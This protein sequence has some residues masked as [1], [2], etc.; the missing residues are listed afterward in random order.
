MKERWAGNWILPKEVKQPHRTKS[1]GIGGPGGPLR[2]NDYKVIDRLE[3]GLRSNPVP[4]GMPG[5]AIE[6]TS[7]KGILERLWRNNNIRK[8]FSAEGRCVECWAR[9]KRKPRMINGRKF[10]LL[11]EYL[12][13]ERLLGIK[14]TGN[15][16]RTTQWERS[17]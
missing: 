17:L 3:L 13:G 14:M 12:R 5:D 7:I 4:L 1:R 9:G 10:C 16:Y 6:R 11:H 8:Q 15:T 2:S